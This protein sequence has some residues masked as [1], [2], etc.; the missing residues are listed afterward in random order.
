M[1]VSP[2]RRPGLVPRGAGMAHD[3]G[4]ATPDLSALPG[5]DVLLG[6]A[7]D[8]VER[9]GRAAT[10][11]ALRRAV[12]AARHDVRSGAAAPGIPALLA[13]AADDLTSRRPGP[14]R[15]VVNATGVVLHTNLGRAPL[16]TEAR[17]A[18]AEAAGYCDLEYDLATGRRGSRG[19]RVDLLLAEA[20]CAESAIAVN[21]AAAA[22]VLALSTLAAGRQVLV[23]RGELVEIGG[24]FRLPEIMRA[25]GA[26]LVEVGTT[27]RTRASDYATAGDDVALILKVHPSNYRI[28]GFSEAPTTAQLGAVARTRD[29]PLLYDVGS[30]LLEDAE[31]PWLAGEPSVAGALAAGA[32]LVCCSGDKLLGGPQAGLLVGRAGLVS[33]CRSAPLSRALRL[34]KLRIAALVATLTAH[35]RGA[36]TEVPTWALLRADQGE[37][38][39]RSARLADAVGGTVVDGASLVG[40]GAAPD[41]AVPGTLV[42]IGVPSPDRAAAHLRAGAPPIIVR[43]DDDA[44]LVD[45]RT[46][47]PGEDLL[48]ADRLRA[49]RR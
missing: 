23:S 28:T 34:D 4:M 12:D 35:L 14:P 20:A 13:A 44:L 29:V 17:A 21:N 45:L 39:D 47:D 22:L 1:A 40:G 7:R 18:V 8:L 30:G 38:A 48:I 43:I 33:A 3:G 2:D 15:R 42:R 49:A 27:N 41:R 5:I 36:Q 24:S 32:D 46:V 9:H 25:S 10:A 6:G 26:R 37:L 11:A 16:S 31:E 19:A